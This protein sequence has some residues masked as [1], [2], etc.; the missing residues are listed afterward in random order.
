MALTGATVA[1]NVRVPPTFNEVVGRQLPMVTLVG[2]IGATVI[3]HVFVLLPSWVV[4]VIVAEPT[5]TAVTTPVVLTVATLVL[6]LD[7]VTFWF[8][9]LAGATVAVNVRVPPTFNEVVG[10]QLPIVTLVGTIGA[11]VITHVLVLLP[12][13][14]VAVIVAVPTPTAVT[15]PVV[16][17]VA[18]LMLLLD[19][20]TF[21]L[22]ALAGATVAVN[23]RVPP[24]F[25]GVVG[26]QLPIVTLVGIIGATVITHVLVLLPSTVVAVSV[27]EPTPTAVTTPVV[28][29]VATAVLL[30]D[31]VT[32]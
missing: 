30:L 14:V 19:H 8:V 29:T 9:A 16:L 5:P 15:T 28:L 22:V 21:W 3:T 23:A 11:T 20:V 31:H 6:L 10:R 26:R 24:T 17:T 7:H 4:T 32:F 27:A 13:T 12:S 18:T 25:N 2:T 1:V